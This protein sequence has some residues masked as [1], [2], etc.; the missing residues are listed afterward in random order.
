MPRAIAVAAVL[1]AAALA[2]AAPR[3]PPFVVASGAPARVAALYDRGATADGWQALRDR[4]TGVAAWLW[5]RAQ[6][7]PGAV[8]DPAI[9]ERAA[10]AFI[11]AHLAELA[12]GSAPGDLVVVAN[13]LDGEVRTVG[14][15]QRYGGLPVIGGQLGVMFAHDHLFAASSHALPRIAIALP[16]AR[17]DLA[18]AHARAEAWLGRPL[19]LRGTPGRAVLPIVRRGAIT[20]AVVDVLDA[21]APGDAWAIY[22]APDGTP[23]ARA[24]TAMHDASNLTYDV[25]VRYATGVRMPFPAAD[26]SITVNAAGTVT[27]D[28]GSF[29]WTGGTTAQVAPGLTG[30]YV[31]I[32]N[33]AGVLATAS[34]TASD[35]QP[36]PW[37]LASD[38]QGDAQLSTYIYAG[39]AK[40]HARVVNPAVSAWLDMPEPFF[41]NETGACNAYALPDEVHFAMASSECQNTG[42]VGDIVFH[43]FGHTLHFHTIIPGV[44]VYDTPLSEGL[45]D[46][47][48]ANL[49]EDPAIGRGLYYDDTPNRNIDPPGYERV[50][51]RDIDAIDPH[52]TGEIVSGSLWDLRKTLVRAL[53]H[54]P[55]VALGNQIFTGVMARA[56][57]IPSS[58]MAAL[59]ADDDDGDL[60]DGTPH[61]C[62]IRQAFGTHGLVDGFATTSVAPP[63]VDGLALSLAVTTPTDQPCPQP[64]V[65]SMTVTW[66]AGTGVP[67]SFQLVPNGTTWSGAIPAQ[68]ADTLVHYAVDI[69]LDDGSEIVFPQNPADPMYELYAGDAVPIACEP[70]D[71]DPMWTQAGNLGN[72]WTWGQPGLIQQAFDP[73]AAHSGSGAYGTDLSGD[74]LYFTDEV[75]STTLPATDVSGYGQVHLQYWRW[76]TVEDARYDQATIAVNGT[77]IWQNAASKPGTL[78]HIDQEWRF[79]DLD[80]T[81]LVGGGSASVTWSLTSD[82][83]NDFGG[84]TLDDVCLVGVDPV[85]GNGILDEGEQCDDGNTVDG[86]GCSST[87]MFEIDS[88]GGGCAAGGAPGLAM[89]ASLLAFRRRRKKRHRPRVDRTH[90]D[91]LV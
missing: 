8:A 59:I 38:E 73:T 35:G 44:G 83:T 39:I 30:R 69:E 13:R 57:D 47:G 71:H 33:A 15:A 49:T 84:W 17:A 41:V 86:D 76:L 21:R 18:I 16:A 2:D 87:C 50:W 24:E 48:C 10:R 91:D 78:D 32:V 82:H 65:T 64:N 55:G 45:A 9:A 85:C 25:G 70:F 26:A 3:E 11:A 80:L 52:V 19:A 58:Y 79:H 75:A 67:S 29:S 1:G 46:Y 77:Q 40:A 4:D 5:G 60:G 88:G 14:F 37:S 42:R 28:D 62:M 56:A 63:V 7:V 12:P 74:G 68:P 81:S 20:Y 54:D 61:Y 72:Q 43:E 53:G 89:C 34:L 51:P 90:D 31:T 22:V 66:Q 6:D 27:G 36:T 23:I